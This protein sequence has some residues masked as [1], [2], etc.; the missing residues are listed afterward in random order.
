MCVHVH[1]CMRECEFGVCACT[2]MYVRVH[3]HECENV[4]VVCMNV[5]TC[6]FICM[7]ECVY[8]CAH[9]HVGMWEYEFVV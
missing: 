8:V 7:C 9:A 6:A 4:Y 5:L 2:C 3:T 1:V